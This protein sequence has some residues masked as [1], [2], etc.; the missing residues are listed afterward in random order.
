MA[1]A[2]AELAKRV[3]GA[4]IA[5][6]AATEVTGIAYDSRSVRPG[7]LFVCIRGFVYDGHDFAEEAVRKGARALLVEHEVDVAA[8]QIVVDDARWAMGVV[9]AAFYGHPDQ[10]LRMIGVTGTNGKTTT[11]FL[12][13]DLLRYAGRRAGMIGTVIQSLGDQDLPAGRTTPESADIHRLLRRMAENGCEACVMEV[14]SHGLALHRTAGLEFDVG[15]FTNLTQDHFDFHRTP[16]E[17]LKAKL[18]LFESLEPGRSGLKGNK[19]AVVNIDDPLGVRFVKAARVPVITYGIRE[20]CDLWASDVHVTARGVTY[21]ARTRGQSAYVRLAL[22]GRFNVYNSLAA[23]AVGLTE[24]IALEQAAEGMAATVVPGR[25]EPVNAGQEF[26]VIV[27]YAHTPD[28]LENVLRTAKS[29]T[30]GRVICVFGAGGDRDKGKRPLM[31]N[32]AAALAD[33]VVITSDNPRSEDPVE[34]CRQVAAGAENGAPCTVI[35][36]RREAIRHAVACAKPG[37]LVLIAGKGHETYQE[38]GGAKLHFDDRE[39]ALAAIRER[40]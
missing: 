5:G 16:E 38:V 33:Y 28:S 25:F 14:S 23:L 31:G 39:E 2:I 13:R 15:V 6:A 29:L 18:K 30:K 1:I 4:R 20:G 17:Y 19:R 12:V 32:V 10:R 3:A 36:D 8:P 34:I 24:G 22:T 37:D 11:A 26:A 9:V 21:V 35:V 7:D 27:D 40:L